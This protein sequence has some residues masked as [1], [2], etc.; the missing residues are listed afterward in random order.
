M[1]LCSICYLHKIIHLAHVTMQIIP[2]YMISSVNSKHM[3]AGSGS[4]YITDNYHTNSGDVELGTPYTHVV[5]CIEDPACLWAS[6]SGYV[7]LHEC[8]NF[9]T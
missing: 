4:A 6:C 1:I 5:Y 9:I 2:S 3:H 8:Y 7:R